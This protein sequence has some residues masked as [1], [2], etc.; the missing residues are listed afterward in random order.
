[1]MNKVPRNQKG[2]L[3]K[4]NDNRRDPR[5]ASARPWEWRVCRACQTLVPV[6]CPG[7]DSDKLSDKPRDVIHAALTKF[8]P[9]PS[10]LKG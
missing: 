2:K 5:Y 10:L 3:A 6:R 8:G 9:P 1:M 4:E 7:C